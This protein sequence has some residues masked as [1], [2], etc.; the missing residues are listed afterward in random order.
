MS[1]AWGGSRPKLRVPA[2]LALVALSAIAAWAQAQG[3]G[4]AGTLTDIRSRPLDGIS[5][6][7][8][9]V[10]SGA[11]VHTTTGRGGA[12]RFR[13]L[14]P[15][16]Y[17]LLAINAQRQQGT[18]RGVQVLAGHESRVQTAVALASPPPTG[19][20]VAAIRRVSAAADRA[21]PSTRVSERAAS[22]P[23]AVPRNPAGGARTEAEGPPPG[24]GGS[25]P[26]VARAAAPDLSAFANAGAFSVVSISG[27]M[28]GALLAAVGAARLRASLEML[29]EI[30]VDDADAMNGAAIALT[31][32]EVQ[33][34]PLPGRD[35]ESLISETTAQER[36]EANEED[37]E[38]P[39]QQ[40]PSV[41]V[42]GTST[43]MAFDGRMRGQEGRSLLAAPGAMDSAVQEFR[44]AALGSVA[45]RA[46]T[47]E[48]IQL[49]TRRGG[50]GL[51]GQVSFYSRQSPWG[52]RNP[53]TQWVKETTPASATAI[54]VF[55]SMPFSP[56][57][58][59]NRLGAGLG[60]GVHWNHFLWFAAFDGEQRDHPGIATV[61]HPDR[62]FAQPSN[63]ELQVLSARLG[64]GSANPVVEG[65]RAY[66]GPLE[67][68]AELLGP[69]PRTSRNTSGFG[70]VDWRAG[71]RHRFTLQAAQA[72]WSAPGGGLTRASETFGTHSF[73][74]NR[75]SST[76]T[77]ARWEAQFTPHLL[78]I[79]QGSMQRAIVNHPAAAP[80]NFERGFLANAWGQLPQI[81][82]DSRYGFTMGNPARFGTGSSPDE[83]VY[84]AQENVD[85]GRGTVLLRAGL[86]LRHSADATSMIRNHTGTYVYG[87]VENFISDALAFGKYG[88]GDALDPMHQHNCDQRGRPWRDATGQLHGLGYLPCYSHYTQTLGPTDWHLSTND[89]AGFAGLQW[90]PARQ[91]ALTAAVRWDREDLPPPIA[92]VHNPDL[93]LTQ[94]LPALGSTWSPRLG[95]AWG[96][97]ESGWPVLRAGYAMFSGRTNNGM[98][99]TALTQTGSPKGDLKLVMRAGDNR[100]GYSGGAPPFP[101]VL[102]G[103]PAQAAKPGAVEFAANFH[104]AEIHQGA[105]A[106]DKR[107]PG[108]V[109]VSLSAMVSLARR[110]PVTMD[111]NFDATANPKTITYAVVDGTGKGPIRKPQITVP[112]FAS[113]PDAGASGRLNAKY[114]QVTEI[115]SR[116]NATYEAGT[117]RLS[118]YGRRG[119]SFHARYTYSH[120]M[121]WNPEEGT[122]LA[123]STVFDPTDFALEYGPSD[124]DQRHSAAASALWQAPWK[125]SGLAG[126]L[127]NGWLLSGTAQYH[128]GLPYTMRTAGSIP[129]LFEANGAMMLGLGPGMNGYGGDDRVYGVGRNTYRHPQTWK[130]DL[131]LGRR[132]ALGRGHEL[133]LL[134]ESFNLFNHQNVTEVETTGYTIQSGGISGSLP[135]LNFLSGLKPGQTEFGLPLNINAVDFYRE[136]QFDLGLRMKF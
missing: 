68:L 26:M 66:S 63:D 108:R 60:G 61:K 42:E 94:R 52:A 127:T 80:S 112:F 77:V 67:S 40:K 1:E 131:R 46:A 133:E 84:E 109:L 101:Y 20:V 91:L 71:E 27:R 59:E 43:R 106:I 78:A 124:Q 30:A 92:L 39:P 33:Q 89:W 99:L 111:T 72:L 41:V 34:L 114:Q 103:T 105:L 4:I 65:I 32:E 104:N 2:A 129:R 79:T 120:A 81:T 36:P 3:G 98:L 12:Y 87:S 7:L 5:I 23:P 57:D 70:R 82:V 134:A 75:G 9:N 125:R 115:A 118:R 37:K 28:P 117:V 96:R 22:L 102:G 132:I 14:A 15:G 54:P 88:M 6:T 44:V 55:A 49:Q 56:P 85:W 113:W 76:W 24:S 128:S 135:T 136:R 45:G 119:L 95:L 100:P 10:D 31:A 11:E 64:L 107:L 35:W 122:T 58:T 69:A 123:R 83:H 110:L 38:E 116:A 19:T 50:E 51:H 62:F 74:S 18:V 13:D 29:P 121:D 17:E 93:P 90:R 73:G 86:D 16:E 53:F 25:S 21:N 130:A 126:R 47:G 48:R 97:D 8:R